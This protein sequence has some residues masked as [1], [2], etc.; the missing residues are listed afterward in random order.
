MILVDTGP[1]IALF[2]PAD[3]WHA[4]CVE[5]RKGVDE[6]LYTTTP[7]LKEAFHLLPSAS[8][9]AR[10][11]ME[12]ITQGGLGLW[13]LDD[14][15]LER[16][17][18]LMVRYSDLRMDFADASLVTAAERLRVQKVFTIDRRDFRTYRARRGHRSVP[19]ELIN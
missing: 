14:R 6:P 15:G 10:R 5:V 12:F 11:L 13:F 3:A 9:G 4:R 19:F 18:E 17:F 16:A 7:V 8:V 1:L 2:D